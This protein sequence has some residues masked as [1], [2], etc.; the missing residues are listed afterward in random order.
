M[1]EFDFQSVPNVQLG[2]VEKR[3][4]LLFEDKDWSKWDGGKIGGDPVRKIFSF[5]KLFSYFDEISQQCWLDPEN[6]PKLTD[7]ECTLCH[8]AMNFLLQVCNCFIF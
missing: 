7:Y 5:Y 1:A 6:H 2:I 4:K 3:K 8:Q